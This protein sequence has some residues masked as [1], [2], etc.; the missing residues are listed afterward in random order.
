MGVT[1]RLNVFV[2]KQHVRLAT[3]ALHVPR[4]SRT[5]VLLGMGQLT[6]AETAQRFFGCE[7]LK[8]PGEAW[9]WHPFALVETAV[10]AVR[11]AGAGFGIP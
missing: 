3:V 5:S 10:V 9:P 7:G 4:N 11:I 2:T 6:A 1:S 8:E